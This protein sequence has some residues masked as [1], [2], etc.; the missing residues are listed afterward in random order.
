MILKV[1][2]DN[3]VWDFLFERNI[4]LSEAL[5][6]NEFLLII[7]REAE[8][9]IPPMPTEKHEYVER[10]MVMANVTTDSYFGFYDERYSVNEQRSGGFGDKFDT[11]VKGGRFISRDESV[12][13]KSEGP[14]LGKVNKK[15]HLLNNEA[16]ISL[17][18]RAR[19]IHSIILTLDNKKALKRARENTGRVIDIKKWDSET[20]LSEFIKSELKC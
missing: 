2:I 4:D 8:F 18:A 10:M 5:P 19:V 14:L 15:T 17:A 12:A 6:S 1:Y 11:T 9:E 16:D 3:N 20:S 7:T 13:I